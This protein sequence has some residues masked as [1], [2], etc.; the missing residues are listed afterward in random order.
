MSHSRVDFPINV[1]AGATSIPRP[2]HAK[3][4]IEVL[5]ESVGRVLGFRFS[6]L[7]TAGDITRVLVPAL[8][9][10]EEK[11]GIIRLVIEVDDFKGESFGASMED[12][13]EDRKILNLEREAIVGE[14]GWD[15]WQTVFQDFFFLFPAADLVF[16]GIRRRSRYGKCRGPY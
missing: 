16:Y 3:F 6:G 8:E 9:A 4:M 2:V 1:L 15:A 12:R 11:F 5:P 14:E 7:I 10:A 13:K